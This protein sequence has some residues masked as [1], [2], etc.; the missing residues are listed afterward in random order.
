MI[1]R[2]LGIADCGLRIKFHRASRCGEQSLIRNPLGGGVMCGSNLGLRVARFLLIPVACASGWWA[3][4]GCVRRTLTIET[5][6]AGAIVVLN[7]Q[8][9]GATPVSTDFIWY[10]D[11]DVA[12]RKKNFQTLRTNI[13]LKAP[14]YQIPPID[15]FT[16]V[17]WPGHLH[18][19]RHAAFTLT[20]LVLPSREEVVQRAMDL[21][22]QALLDV[23][24]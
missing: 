2:V 15:F 24:P 4:S 21:R 1:D 12:I 14:W 22:E 7:D 16:D 18:D 13:V 9:I 23:E 19:Q 10:G 17:L 6:P 5:E 3:S 11:Y 20:P 8:E